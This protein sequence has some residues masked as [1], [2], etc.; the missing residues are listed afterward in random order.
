ME[1]QVQ[2]L[3]LVDG[4]WVSRPADVYQI[5]ARAQQQADTE[6]REPE[7]K[8]QNQVPELG[9]L[10]RT[11]FASPFVKFVLPANIRHKKLNDV[12]FLGENSV[13]LKEIGAYGHLRHAATKSNFTGKIVAARK[14][15]EP[16]KVEVSTEYGAPLK[17]AA[18]HAER[19]SLGSD[20]PDV[21]PPEVIVLTLNTRTLM[22]LWARQTRT[23]SVGF[24]QKTVRL[25]ASTSRHDRLGAFLAI[26]PKCRAMAV[27]A[28]EGRFILYKTKTMDEW[29]EDVRSGRDGVPIVDER[30]FSIQGRI[31]HMEFLSPGTG[32]D[33]SHVVLLFVLA[34]GGKTKM[35]CYDWDAR[36]DLST[37]SARAER[38]SVDPG[39]PC[40][41]APQLLG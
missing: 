37:A 12:V 40:L 3:V 11:V 2:G 23:G 15:G 25:P 10:S 19:R 1:H 16:R 22:F 41:I 29:R 4:E 5:M 26:D 7:L 36:H 6:M 31:M 30:L 32:Q 18:V 24:R 35:S 33:D 21:L 13:H 34:H 8:P 39:K 28:P 17:R 20:E 9:I 27:A 14:F 38:V